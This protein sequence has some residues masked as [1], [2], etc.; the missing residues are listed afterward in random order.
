MAKCNINA[1]SQAVKDLTS[2]EFS[3]IFECLERLK[4]FQA[5]FNYAKLKSQPECFGFW[6]VCFGFYGPLNLFFWLYGAEKEACRGD[7]STLTGETRHGIFK[8]RLPK[9]SLTH[10]RAFITQ[11]GCTRRK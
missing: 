5:L 11:S 8:V 2:M 4:Y 9:D 6:G 3:K 1:K 10:Y 7:D